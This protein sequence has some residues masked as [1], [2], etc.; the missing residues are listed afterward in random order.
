[1]AGPVL[2]TGEVM[3][4]S[5]SLLNDSGKSIYTYIK[6]LPYLN[7]ALSELQEYFELNE[8][9]VVD[10]VSAVI[11]VPAGTTSIGFS[12]DPPIVDTPYLPDDLIEP[13]I[14]W[15]R[16]SGIN[17]YISMSKVDFLPRYMEGIEINQFIYYVWESQEIRLLSS[18]QDNDIK[19][20]YIRNLFTEFTDT[21]G[22]DEIAVLNSR[23]FLQYRNAG[24]CAEFIG[25]NK[26]RADEL[27]A[28]ASLAMDRVVGIG[29][30]GRQAINTRHKPFR[31]SYKR[32]SFS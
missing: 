29:T 26:T 25:E 19:M 1:M 3:D 8:V 7:M 23:S 17:P 5:A 6:Q 4:K 2:L 11:E 30:K 12:P 32:R 22:E 28:F 18:N 13:Q 27:N 21:D 15:E 24:L 9:P 20:N 16:Q 31:A 14:L 10:N